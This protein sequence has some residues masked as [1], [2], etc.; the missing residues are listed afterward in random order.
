M[1]GGP[2]CPLPDVSHRDPKRCASRD[3]KVLRRGHCQRGEPRRSG[4]GAPPSRGRTPP[5][6]PSHACA[7]WRAD[8]RVR[9]PM[10]HIGIRSIARRATERSRVAVTVS[11]VNLAE[12]VT[13]HRPPGT[14]S[15]HHTLTRDAPNGGRTS[16]SASRCFTSGSEA[17][18]GARPERSCVPDT[19]SEVNLAEAVTEHRPPRGMDSTPH[20]LTRLRPNG[21][22]TSVSASR[23]F[24][25]GSEALRVARPAARI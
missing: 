24:T 7:R 10:F 4:D 13:E 6:T 5:S 20:T 18:R 1:E 11:E 25:S 23:C 21:G 22:R 19:V 9:F 14:D 17:V 12:A 3:P 2:P 8:L 15:T 16:T